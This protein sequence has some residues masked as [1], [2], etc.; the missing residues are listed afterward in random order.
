[1]HE[2]YTDF[3]AELE[4]EF[5]EIAIDE[6]GRPRFVID[7]DAKAEWAIGKIREITGEHQRLIGVCQEQID[8]YTERKAFYEDRLQ[9]STGH[10][11]YLL[12]EYFMTVKPSKE[13]K[14]Q[15]K[16]ELPGGDLIMKKATRTMR[17]DDEK[18]TA[19]LYSNGFSDYL[20]TTVKPAWGDFKKRLQI[21]GDD[22]VVAETG[23]VIPADCVTVEDKPET[24]EV[25]IK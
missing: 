20:K 21:I 23:E 1:M 25:K 2:D 11:Q 18:L 5:G 6:E 13:T 12:G 10:L 3:F 17:A 16:Y 19:W 24:F 9:R 15:T 22:V 4:E 8:H 14:T 7:S